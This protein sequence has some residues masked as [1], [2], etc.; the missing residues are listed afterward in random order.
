[1]NAPP[2]PE[3]PPAR[4]PLVR[5][6]GDMPRW[7]K[8]AVGAALGAV[9]LGALFGAFAGGET[10]ADPGSAGGGASGLRTSLIDG[11]PG[12]GAGG[13]GSAADVEEPAA[14][15][16]FRLGF[17]FLAGFCIGSFLRAALRVAAI[18]FGFWLVATMALS[19]YGVLVVD[20]QAIE[21]LWQRFAGNVEAEWS[22]FRRFLT[23]S[24]PSAG[25]ALAGL[26]IGLKRH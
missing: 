25:L 1:M 5:W 10:A 8:I 23:G 3:T 7:K 19:H 4:R 16:V 2:G 6:L 24:L 14:K 26:A 11:R 12:T 20:W 15:G 17:S 18:A 13:A 22:S 21:S 9:V